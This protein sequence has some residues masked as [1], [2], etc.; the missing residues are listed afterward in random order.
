MY[1]DPRGGLIDFFNGS[2]DIKAKTIRCVG[3]PIKR[4]EED[5][6]RIIRAIRFLPN[7]VSSSNTERSMVW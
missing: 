5:H 4:F 2:S 3:D 6:L 7:W 1:F